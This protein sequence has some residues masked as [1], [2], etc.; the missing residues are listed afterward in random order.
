MAPGLLPG[1]GV[2][3]A[4]LKSSFQ[5]TPSADGP[6]QAV[7]AG[8]IVT[9]LQQVEYKRFKMMPEQILPSSAPFWGLYFDDVVRVGFAH[10]GLGYANVTCIQFEFT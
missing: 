1:V 9:L 5:C 3:P 8:Q 4:R 2:H 10:T 6:P 7:T